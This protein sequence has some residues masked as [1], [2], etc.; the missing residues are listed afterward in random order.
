[1]A[2]GDVKPLLAV[3]TPVPSDIDI[4]QSIAPLHISAIAEK[5]G[6]LPE[7]LDLYGTTKAKVGARWRP[8]AVRRQRDRGAAAALRRGAASSG[9]EKAAA[10]LRSRRRSSCP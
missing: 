6:I 3:K 2:G 1:M 5:L 7:E 9:C 8:D 4:A 10:P